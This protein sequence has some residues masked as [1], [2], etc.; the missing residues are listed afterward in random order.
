MDG[1]TMDKN[2]HL[3]DLIDIETLQTMQEAFV[4]MTGF[5]AITTDENGVAVTEGSNFTDFCMKYTRQSPI[6][7]KR[8]EQC[9][10]LGQKKLYKKGNLVLIVVMQDL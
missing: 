5:A 6:G 3:T 8:C 2:L 4:K 10:K 7:K 1:V 9:N